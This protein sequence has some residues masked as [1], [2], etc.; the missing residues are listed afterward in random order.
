MTQ[1]YIL[2]LSLFKVQVRC[3]NGT[4]QDATAP[5][6]LRT[7]QSIVGFYVTGTTTRFLY[8]GKQV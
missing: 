6:T 7:A 5:V 4:W 3:T 1:P 2:P 8:H